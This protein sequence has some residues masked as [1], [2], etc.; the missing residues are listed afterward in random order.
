MV[1]NNGTATLAQKPSGD[2]SDFSPVVF[3]F[4]KKTAGLKK[5]CAGAYPLITL[6]YRSIRFRLQTLLRYLIEKQ[7]FFNSF[8]LFIFHKLILWY[9]SLKII[10]SNFN[11]LYLI[12]VDI[13][14]D[15]S[16]Q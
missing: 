1:A 7:F 6:N 11:I 12:P 15:L 2:S 14:H 5:G 4:S 10:I 16:H 9:F 8:K 13:S 3:Y